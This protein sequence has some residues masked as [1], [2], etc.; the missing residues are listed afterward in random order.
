[1]KR[2]FLM[3]KAKEEEL[4]MV[5]EAIEKSELVVIGGELQVYVIEDNEIFEVVNNLK[6]IGKIEVEE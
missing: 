2:I 6:K 5:R 4:I 3:P 1:M